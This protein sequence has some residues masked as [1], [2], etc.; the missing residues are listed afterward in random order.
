ML[1]RT[2]PLNSYL[3]FASFCS[4]QQEYEIG[5]AA[6]RSSG[7]QR[8]PAM[9]RDA[10]GRGV[11]NGALNVGFERRVC[12]KLRRRISKIRRDGIAVSRRGRPLGA[13]K[14]DRKSVG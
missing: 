5:S 7:R 4:L 10:T 14:L 8:G 3:I 1:A 12:Q 11:G 6:R 13:D 2:G 9:A